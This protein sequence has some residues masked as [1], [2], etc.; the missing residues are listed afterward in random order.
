ML[1]RSRWDPTSDAVYARYRS[2]LGRPSLRPRLIKLTKRLGV[3]HR[4]RGRERERLRLREAVKH[5]LE[6]GDRLL[7]RRRKNRPNA[8]EVS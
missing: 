8:A 5:S 3:D 1:V 2:S 4:E 6:P 7:V